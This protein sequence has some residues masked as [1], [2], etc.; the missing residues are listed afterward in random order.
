MSSSKPHQ[1]APTRTP[2][3]SPETETSPEVQALLRRRSA[4]TPAEIVVFR[5][6]YSRIYDVYVETLRCV[7]R[8]RG[9]SGRVASDLV[10]DAFATLWSQTLAA[11]FPESI[12]AKLFALASGLARNH[13]RREGRK[14]V[15]EPLSSSRGDVPGSFPRPDRDIDVRE[16]A[17][18]LFE[19]LSEP[20]KEVIALI[21]LGDLDVAEAARQMG[22]PR[23]TVSD[24][25][26][27]ALA[28][29]TEMAEELFTPSER[30]L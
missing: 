16:D 27:A 9:A 14:P 24:R 1:E 22:L 7:V 30:R 26:T 28:L 29:L 25:L 20:H 11:G 18:V 8:S 15:T 2:G 19:R 13:A 6:L 12:K 5:K 10:H 4:L 23:M 21:V 17:R 3:W